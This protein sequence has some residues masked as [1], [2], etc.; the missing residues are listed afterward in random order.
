MP[1]LVIALDYTDAQ[2]ALKMASA[3]K[4]TGV[5]MKVGLELFTIEGPKIVQ[6]LKEMGFPVMLDLKLHDIP[7]TVQGGV[8]AASLLGAD[9]ITLHLIGG[10]R[11]C[12]AA[13]EEIGKLQHRPLLFGV[14]VLTSMQQGELPVI[15]AN[16]QSLAFSLAAK[17]REWELNGIVCSGLEVQRIKQANPSLLCLT[18]G[19]RP[20]GSSAD[21]QRRTVTP[22][23][24]VSYGSDFLVVG[25]PVTK[26][27][28]PAQVAEEILASMKR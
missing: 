27:A 5:W 16:L 17:A 4:N 9:L 2:S 24:A 22:E 1:K 21:D 26:A 7:N 3:L 13:V 19:I 11:M 18:P 23:Q 14:T 28:N 10:E 20:G 6:T 12:R 25:R 15:E 8:R